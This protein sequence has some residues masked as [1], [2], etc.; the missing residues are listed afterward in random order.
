[1]Q[2]N[3]KVATIQNNRNV[4]RSKPLITLVFLMSLVILGSCRPIREAV[5]PDPTKRTLQETL[6][7]MRQNETSF[8]FLSTRF[9]GSATIDGVNHSVSGTLRIKS[10][11]AI[12]VSVT[13]LLGIEIARLLVTPDTV[14]LVNRLDNTFY[15]GDMDV[16]NR[17]FGTY[18][19]FEMLQALMVGNDFSH[20]SSDGFKASQ[21]N[22]NVVLFSGN[23]YP[24]NNRNSHHF[25]H[26]LVVNGETYRIIESLLHEKGPQRSLRVK[27]NGFS[28]IGDQLI[29]QEIS[30]VFSDASGQTAVNM[31]FSRTVLN[32][33]RSFAFT[34]PNHYRQIRF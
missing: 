27:Y 12:F 16:L 14:K 4:R 32:E 1:M 34:I 19:D 10:D 17:M 33:E 15:A 26:R 2:A 30:M 21:E 24:A 20:F 6:A 11:S 28:R 31:R 23:R 5:I 25:Q 7:G 3:Q 22:G 29:P 9:S 8:T 18:L 13:P